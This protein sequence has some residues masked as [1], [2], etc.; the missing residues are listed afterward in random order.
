MNSRSLLVF[1]DHYEVLQISPNADQETIHRVY[2]LQSQRFH[3][4]NLVT[5]DAQAFLRV[6]EAYRVLG[7]PPKRAAFDDECTAVRRR[8]AR[9]LFER[10]NAAQGVDGE[11]QKRQE[12][13]SLL[14]NRRL[15]HPDQPA[16]GLRDLES[17]MAVPRQQ[18]EF[19]IWY[20]KEGGFLVRSDS[21]RHTITMKGCE[22]V[23]SGT[24]E[25]PASAD[26][27]VSEPHRLTD[28]SRL[29]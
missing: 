26:C 21:A 17:L 25:R 22:L 5:G 19:S 24:A 2:R 7:D 4:D 13:L 16:M 28:G 15:S 23:E 3:P 8:K 20:L 6:S 29:R 11:R 10:A 14:Y 1:V 18:L 12:I 9:D 27:A